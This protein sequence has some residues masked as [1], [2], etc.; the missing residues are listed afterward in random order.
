MI[1]I[2][3]DVGG[4]EVVMVEFFSNAAL[5]LIGFSITAAGILVVFYG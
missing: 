1:S 3:P 5:L 4:W 2:Q